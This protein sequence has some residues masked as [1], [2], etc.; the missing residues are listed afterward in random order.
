MSDFSAVEGL[1][2]AAIEDF[3][4]GTLYNMLLDAYSFEPRWQA[5]F[6]DSWREYDRFI[7]G[8]PR[9]AKSCGFI[10]VYDGQPI[11]HIT[12]NPTNAPEHVEIGHNCVLC[13]Y[14][15]RGYGRIQLL[16]ALDIIRREYAPYRITVTTNAQ[17]SAARRNYE[18]VGFRLIR[19]RVNDSKCAFAGEYMDYEIA[20]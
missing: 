6:D 13:K 14:K 15:G 16:T 8:N 4:R 18:S 7:Y 10:S 11:G 2:F 5:T 9:I 12:W 20:I 3:P 1:S 19:T 17:L